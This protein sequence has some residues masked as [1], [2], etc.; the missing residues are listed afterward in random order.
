MKAI[1]ITGANR[2][3]GKGFVEYS[4]NKGYRVFAGV[5]NI[6][7]FDEKLTSNHN[8]TLIPVDITDE[9]SITNAFLLVK[10]ETEHLDF[11]VNNAGNNKDSATNNN[12]DIVCKLSQLDRNV[13]LDMFNV[14]SISPM[15]VL[16]QFL[17]LLQGKPSFVINISSARSSNKDENQ[18]TN[19]N[20]GYRA[21]KAALN[22]MTVASLFD[23]PPNVR[24]FAV[25]PGSVKT[26]MNPT[27]TDLP[28][29]QASKII[30]ITNNWKDEFNGKFL[31]YDGTIYPL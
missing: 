11:L 5:R 31:R 1:F 17:P 25:H 4:L 7:D 20:Y 8:L 24:T 27:G 29:D 13:L 6:L 26:D 14:N 28:I 16:K 30:E 2:G 3:L 12:K 9:V 18:N 21:S 10:K 15:M 23:L 22:L 19:G